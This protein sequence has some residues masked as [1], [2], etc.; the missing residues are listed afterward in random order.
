ML[1]YLIILV[2]DFYFIFNIGIF[3]ADV[4]HPDPVLQ[5]EGWILLRGPGGP[6]RLLLHPKGNFSL[7]SCNNM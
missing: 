2:I 7:S 3:F 5:D 1:L 4:G 6:D